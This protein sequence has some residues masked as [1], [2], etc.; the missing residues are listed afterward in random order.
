MPDYALIVVSGIAVFA[1]A[2]LGLLVTT[3]TPSE[4]RRIYYEIS[5]GIIG[6]IG[7]VAIIWGGF[8]TA[9]MQ[10]NINNGIGSIRS[11]QAVLQSSQNALPDKVIGL[12]AK[13]M[14][15]PSAGG[16]YPTNVVDAIG[17]K[18]SD[19]QLKQVIAPALVNG[20]TTFAAPRA[21]GILDVLT[22]VGKQTV[23]LLPRSPYPGEYF[24]IKDGMGNGGIEV[25]GSGHL[26]DGNPT[27][28]LPF[29]H[30]AYRVTFDGRQWLIT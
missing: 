11:G 4:T 5:F 9:Q 3:R 2:M 21:S 17:S 27:L 29:G 1:Q 26:I 6:A 13:L 8:R 23:I 24:D 14:G 15:V 10:A 25:R 20:G 30:Q 7:L 18:I 12:M 28:S 16:K 22:K 19:L